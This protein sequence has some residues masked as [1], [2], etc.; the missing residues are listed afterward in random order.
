MSLSF[1]WQGKVISS[2][3]SITDLVAFHT[4][5]RD[6]EDS[7]DGALY[8]VTHTWK[9]VSLSSGGYF[10]ALDL[11]NGWQLKFP[12]PGNYTITGNLGG[13]IIPVAGAYVERKTSVAFVTTAAGGGGS[14]SLSPADIDAVANAVWA[15][16]FVGKLLTVAKFLGLK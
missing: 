13:T 4:A 6:A 14:S 2:T 12:N 3:A 16:T 11:I 15:H 7:V 1:D 5:L 9:A 8:P 10:Y